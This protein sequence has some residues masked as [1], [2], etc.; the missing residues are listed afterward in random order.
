MLHYHSAMYC[1]G[2]LW[3]RH[4]ICGQTCDGLYH[5]TFYWVIFGIPF[6]SQPIKSALAR[7]NQHWYLPYPT[8]GSRW[9]VLWLL[10]CRST[11]STF[12]VTWS[13]FK[14]PFRGDY[15]QKLTISTLAVKLSVSAIIYPRC[16]V[17]VLTRDSVGCW[18]WE[19]KS[20]GL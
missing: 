10:F 13:T 2:Q 16:T 7:H 17:L 20:H 18:D 14:G 9:V 5:F 4:M 12:P 8:Y 6:G 19:I 11:P 1:C 15:T 3:V